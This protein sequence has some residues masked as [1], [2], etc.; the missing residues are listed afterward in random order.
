MIS[1][2]SISILDS[3]LVRR[4]TCYFHPGHRHVPARPVMLRTIEDSYKRWLTAA[5]SC[6]R[7]SRLDDV[8]SGVPR[9]GAANIS[10]DENNTEYRGLRTCGNC[11]PC[12]ADCTALTL[13]HPTVAFFCIFAL[14]YYH[15]RLCF[16]LTFY[17]FNALT[18]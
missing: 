5:H 15:H 12:S 16:L 9:S 2:D 17:V 10:C 6:R 14:L 8:W 3:T 4:T 1:I 11:R 7:G 18:P 13:I